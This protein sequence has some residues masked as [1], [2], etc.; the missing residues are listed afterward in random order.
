V[1][2]C[3]GGL[4]LPLWC[5]VTRVFHHLSRTIPVLSVT[6]D[7]VFPTNSFVLNVP[8]NF[9]RNLFSLLADVVVSSLSVWDSFIS[10]A[11][12][13]YPKVTGTVVAVRLRSFLICVRIVNTRVIL[14][15][16][17]VCSQQVSPFIIFCTFLS[18]P[19][20]LTPRLYVHLLPM[21]PVGHAVHDPVAAAATGA[22]Q[23]PS[24]AA[25][26]RVVVI[27]WEQVN[28]QLRMAPSESAQRSVLCLLYCSQ[29]DT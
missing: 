27:L 14:L 15:F 25:H 13:A 21:Q 6:L 17:G 28:R 1:P 18:R 19:F 8:A 5:T 26:H 29:S 24:A 7:G 23:N 4:L 10:D 16:P 22:V 20:P 9:Q 2:S 3:C 12:A 11:H